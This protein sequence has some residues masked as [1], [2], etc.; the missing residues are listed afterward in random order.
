MGIDAIDK[1][2]KMIDPWMEIVT[3]HHGMPPKKN[4]KERLQNYFEREDK[5]AALEF[6]QEAHRLFL[7]DFDAGPLLDKSLKERL[8][9]ISWRLAGVAVLADWL[10]SNQDYFQYCSQPQSL[11]VYW[12][13]IALA[14]AKDAVRAL[15]GKPEITAFKNIKSFFPFIQQPTPLQRYAMTEALTDH[16]QLFIGLRSLVKTMH[17]SARL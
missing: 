11:E 2:L 8:R 5:Q 15:P 16:P 14:R 6:V 13:E 1:Y 17:F 12:K 3:G 7:G 9:S 4:L 10:G